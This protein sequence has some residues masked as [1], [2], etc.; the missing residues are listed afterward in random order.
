MGDF[1]RDPRVHGKVGE[2][3]AYGHP[4]SGDKR[5]LSFDINLFL[6]GK[7]LRKTSDHAKF[8]KFWKAL[9]PLFR[10]GGDFKK[11]DGNHYGCIYGGTM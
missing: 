1:Y 3:V 9:H 8:G 7:Y 5:R 11:K 6:N 4:K 10:W 2:K